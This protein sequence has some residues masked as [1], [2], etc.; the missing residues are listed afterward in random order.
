MRKGGNLTNWP[1]RQSI[2]PWRDGR[3]EQGQGDAISSNGRCDKSVNDWGDWF[4][5]IENIQQYAL[6][7]GWV[8]RDNHSISQQI[9]FNK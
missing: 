7:T 8:L 9:I 1:T 5:V 6:L 2:R 4:D 3:E